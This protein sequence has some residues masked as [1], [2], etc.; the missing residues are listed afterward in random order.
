M[1]AS[2]RRMLDSPEFKQMVS[3]R[4]TMSIVLT[5]ALFVTYYGYIL[6]VA[7]DKSLMARRIGEVTTLGIP[8]GIGVILVSWV[9]TAVYVLWANRAHDVE[10]RRLKDKVERD[11]RRETI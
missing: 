11:A 6:L 7:T 3:R 10:V 4:W 9:L 5:L 2:S 1:R 8:L